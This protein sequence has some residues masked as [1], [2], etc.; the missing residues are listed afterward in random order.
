MRA[1]GLDS[2]ELWAEACF[3][4]C[5]ISPPAMAAPGNSS[6]GHRTHSWI[7][8]MPD[9]HEKFTEKDLGTMVSPR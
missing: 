8:K 1:L 6:V 5:V 2:S 7:K 9:L 4:G 3:T